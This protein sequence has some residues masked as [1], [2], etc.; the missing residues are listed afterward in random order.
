MELTTNVA[1]NFPDSHPLAANEYLVFLWKMQVLAIINRSTA[2]PTISSYF[3]LRFEETPHYVAIRRNNNTT[4]ISI[5]N[6]EPSVSPIDLYFSADRGFIDLHHNSESVIVGTGDL[7][8]REVGALLDSYE[9]TSRQVIL[10][11]VDEFHLQL[12]H[13]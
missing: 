4:T 6:N 5:V 13:I 8:L 1:P 10:T 9:I 7:R 3:L 12:F 11:A 2:T